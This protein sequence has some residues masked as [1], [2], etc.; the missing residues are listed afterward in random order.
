MSVDGDLLERIV[1]GILG[2]LR[3]TAT[4]EAPEIA[5]A[6]KTPDATVLTDKVITAELLEKERGRGGRIV[7]GSKAIITPS[8]RDYVKQNRIEL[9]RETTGRATKVESPSAKWKLIVVSGPKNLNTLLDET[10]WSRELAGCD[11]EAVDR[12]VSSICRADAAGVVVLTSKPETV[13]CR[14]NRNSK[15]RGAAV[16]NISKLRKVRTEMGA[17]LLCINP[18]DRSQF[19]LRN[20][21]REAAAGG[22]PSAPKGWRD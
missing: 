1:S 8:A 2:E 12:A 13:A 11:V 10:A 6:P 21:L 16:E 14:A 22:S 17:N 5:P 18:A 20:I 19:D 3:G 4:S 15:V 7:I 9:S